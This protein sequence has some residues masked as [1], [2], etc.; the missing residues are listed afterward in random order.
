MKKFKK[1][2]TENVVNFGGYYQVI[3]DKV[4]TPAG[5]EGK[6]H[7]VKMRPFSIIIPI[8]AA[9]MIYMVKQHRY[10]IDKI[11]LEVPMGFSEGQHP[12]EAAKRELEEETGLSS[13]AWYELGVIYEANGIANIPGFIFV[14]KDVRP[15]A[16]PT[17]DPEDKDMIEVEKYPISQVEMMIGDG[18]ILDS[19]TI[20]AFSRAYFRGLLN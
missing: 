7:V 19:V 8:D 14:A 16:N 11:S 5:T 1:V 4:I 9:G 2:E 13:E 3:T 12:L 15:V 17:R 10:T 6:Y 18:T 20:S